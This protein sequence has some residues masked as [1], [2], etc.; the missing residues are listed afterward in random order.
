[1]SFKTF[2]RFSKTFFT[3]KEKKAKSESYLICKEIIR[4]GC[5]EKTKR[6]VFR[7]R[8]RNY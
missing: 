5:N 2:I 4:K 8:D 6:F 7:K 1:M 3:P